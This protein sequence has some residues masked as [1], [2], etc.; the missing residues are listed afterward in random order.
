[1]VDSVA[2]RLPGKGSSSS[3]AKIL[4]W[5]EAQVGAGNADVIVEP[6]SA[7]INCGVP[8]V[9]GRAK[10]LQIFTRFDPAFTL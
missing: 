4:P 10:V 8:Q 9:K 3:Y 7:S 1:M 5:I 6:Y 2:A